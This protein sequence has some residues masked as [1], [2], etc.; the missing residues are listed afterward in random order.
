MVTPP[1]LLQT[2]T[3]VHG[4]VLDMWEGFRESDESVSAYK[5]MDSFHLGSLSP[6]PHACAS[7]S[8]VFHLLHD[9]EL[10]ITPEQLI[11]LVSIEVVVTVAP[12][13]G[14]LEQI[15]MWIVAT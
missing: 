9:P 4:N 13:L 11:P 12:A 1:L 2:I 8:G 7:S 15:G 14:I 10:T 5:S 3:V 6:F